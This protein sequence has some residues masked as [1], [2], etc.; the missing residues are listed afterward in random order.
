MD[1]LF[2]P[3]RFSVHKLKPA[4]KMATHRIT[5]VDKKKQQGV[6][7]ARRDAATLLAAGKE[8]KARIKVRARASFAAPGLDAECDAPTLAG[9]PPGLVGRARH[10]AGAIDRGVRPPGYDL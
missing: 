10:P 9:L 7:T 2:G 4:L 5:I 8:H 1:F 6:V 3:P